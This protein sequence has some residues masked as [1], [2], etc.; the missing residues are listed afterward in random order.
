MLLLIELLISHLSEFPSD[1]AHDA[2][3]SHNGLL[4]LTVVPLLLILELLILFKVGDQVKG[5]LIE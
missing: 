1:M 3:S 2:G 4:P 5:L